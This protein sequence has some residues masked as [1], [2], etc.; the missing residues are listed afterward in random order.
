M[1]PM[2]K[3]NTLHNIFFPKVTSS[4]HTQQ[5][6]VS[7]TTTTALHIQQ[8]KNNNNNSIIIIINNNN[9]VISFLISTHFL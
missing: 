6:K 4:L 8:D 7:I 5:D 2:D 3:S 1:F 9:K